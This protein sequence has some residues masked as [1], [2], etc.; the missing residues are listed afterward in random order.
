MVWHH[1]VFDSVVEHHLE[2]DLD[3]LAVH[4]WH[5]TT[6]QSLIALCLADVGQHA[7]RI[8]RHFLPITG[9]RCGLEEDARTLKW[10]HKYASGR[11][12]DAI[13]E[14]LLDG[15]L[16]ARFHLAEASA[17]TLGIDA[18]C[19]PFCNA[20]HATCHLVITTLRRFFDWLFS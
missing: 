7:P 2:K 11:N 6:P 3:P 14:K 16:F 8:Q 20:E 9:Q 15:I 19:S 17:L 1:V 10:S 18:S 5:D 13:G 12:A 4:L